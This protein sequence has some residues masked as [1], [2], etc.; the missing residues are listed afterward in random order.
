MKKCFL[1][2]S[3]CNTEE[4][5]DVIRKTIDNIKRYGI[6]ICVHA[7]YPLPVDIQN[8]V[9]Y[10]IYDKSNPVLTFEKDGRGLLFWKRHMKSKTKINTIKHDYGYTVLQQYKRGAGFLD[11]LNKYDVINVINYDTNFTE[12]FYLNNESYMID[13][14]VVLYYYGEGRDFHLNPLF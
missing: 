5:V 10:Y 1:V 13:N 2:T 11:S 7:H 14:D 4:K 3:Y 9:N 12:E 6:D 8:D